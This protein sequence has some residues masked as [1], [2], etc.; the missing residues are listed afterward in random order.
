MIDEL[1]SAAGNGELESVKILLQ[2]GVDINGQDWVS[3]SLSIILNILRQFLILYISMC[4][5]L[6]YICIYNV[7]R[8][9]LDF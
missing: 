9:H 3:T 2:N 1:V 8:A 7:P 6:Y 4:M 5:Q